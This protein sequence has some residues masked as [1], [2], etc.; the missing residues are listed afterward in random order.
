M[1]GIIVAAH[2]EMA[3]GL[4]DSAKMIL[5]KID[6]ATA[7][8]LEENEAPETMRDEITK[9]IKFLNAEEGVIVLLDLFGGTPSNVSASLIKDLNI[10]VVSGV[11]L[12]MLLEVI[13]SRESHD[14]RNLREIAMKAGKEGIVSVNEL[15]ESRTR[16]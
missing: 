4:I 8:V 12:P 9:S 14:L 10:E 13:L 11:N 5:H 7:V 1:I 15:L 16:S 3:N 2:G 6:K